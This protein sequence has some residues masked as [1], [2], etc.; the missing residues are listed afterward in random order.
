CPPAPGHRCHGDQ[1]LGRVVVEREVKLGAWAG[2]A[3][4]DFDGV[5]PGFTATALPSQRLH[6]TYYDT[7]DLRLARWGAHLR[8]RSAEGDASAELPWTVKLPH[9]GGPEGGLARSEVVFPG[10]EGRVPAAVAHLVRGPARSAA[11]GA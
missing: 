1:G 6:A 2:M 5:L 10:S 3:L 9:E 7:A 8:H 4:P 11:L